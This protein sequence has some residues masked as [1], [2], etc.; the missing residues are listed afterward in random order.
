LAAVESKN[1]KP[2]KIINNKEENIT[3][4]DNEE[5]IIDDD[6]ESIIDDEET[7]IDHNKETIVDD[8]PT[9]DEEL[10]N[11]EPSTAEDSSV[12]NI[13]STFVSLSIKPTTMFS[14]PTK[15]PKKSPFL[16]S[17]TLPNPSVDFAETATKEEV[18]EDAVADS[19]LDHRNKTGTKRLPHITS[20][21]CLC[22]ERNG[23][24]DSTCFEEV[25]ENDSDRDGF[26]I[27]RSIDPQDMDAWSAF[28]P[29]EIDFPRLAPLTSRVLF[30]KAHPEAGMFAASSHATM[31]RCLST[32]K[33]PLSSTRRVTLQSRRT[34]T[35]TVPASCLRSP[36]HRS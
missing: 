5:I 27:R 22:P 6:K 7:I 11:E 18:L 33:S 3:D 23:V 36:R 21:D 26:H 19:I 31:A 35:C 34:P 1:S 20:V 8:E 15:T 17:I 12:S 29:D 4:K 28:I 2:A 10:T 32:A 24:F 9:A 25:K 30:S 13:A 16:A 14:T